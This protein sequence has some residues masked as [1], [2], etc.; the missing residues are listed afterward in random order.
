MQRR[1]QS[2]VQHVYR[3][4][5]DVYA[6]GREAFLLTTLGALEQHTWGAQYISRGEFRSNSNDVVQKR[7]PMTHDQRKQYV[8]FLALICKPA[9]IWVLLEERTVTN[10][11]L[12]IEDLAAKLKDHLQGDIPFVHT[13][14]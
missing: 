14:K 7:Y 9:C 5:H 11:L 6:H 2:V 1:G 8:P 10:F 4:G 3:R 13:N 12:A